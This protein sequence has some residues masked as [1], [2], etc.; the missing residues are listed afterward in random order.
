MT[1]ENH[2]P[3]TVAEVLGTPPPP[4]AP[5]V[6]RDALGR[7][8]DA[9][10][11]AADEAG[12]PKKDTKGRFYSRHLGKRA[13]NAPESPRGATSPA[14]EP[15]PDLSD[16]ARAASGAPAPAPAG[17]TGENATVETVIGTLQILL[18]IVG[19]EE[20]VLSP[21]EKL[22]L[23]PPLER[24]FKKY[25]IGAEVLPA[26]VEILFAVAGI[27]IERVKRGGKTATAFAKVKAWIV[28]RFFAHRGAQMGAQMRR[29][30]PADLVAGLRAQVDRL[31]A[32]LAAKTAPAAS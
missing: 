9:A 6:A 14:A 26:E 22:L 29:E 13:G 12:N 17:G 16:I 32:E 10:K 4:A 18:V 1:P 2:D 8:F 31:Q 5:E 21:A 24:L 7:A 23:R 15:A 30:V 19:E 3:V 25:D 11:F 20:G 28:A 27:V